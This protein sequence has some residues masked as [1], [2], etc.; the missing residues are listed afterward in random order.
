M[1]IRE[2][3]CKRA[4]RHQ[5]ASRT[6][7]IKVDLLGTILLC[8]DHYL[9]ALV[10][11]DCQ[12]EDEGDQSGD[13]GVDAQ[14]SGFPRFSLEEHCKKV[15]E[16]LSSVPEHVRVEVVGR[17]VSPGSIR[18]LQNLNDNEMVRRN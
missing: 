10:E 2:Y 17:D 12:N 5:D 4:V 8:V 13:E 3:C 7:E 14:E 1:K 16:D 9:I 6:N 11:N 18:H 15:I